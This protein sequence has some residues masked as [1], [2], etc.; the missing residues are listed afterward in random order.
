[1]SACSE[2]ASSRSLEITS[3]LEAALT[4]YDALVQLDFRDRSQAESKELEKLEV[5]IAVEVLGGWKKRS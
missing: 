2:A 5:Q 3:W 1:M 4:R